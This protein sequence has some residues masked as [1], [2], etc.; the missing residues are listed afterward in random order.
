MLYHLILLFTENFYGSEIWHGNF[1]ELIFVSGMLGGFVR[2]PRDFNGFSF[3]PFNRPVTLTPV[4]CTPMGSLPPQES[5]PSKGTVGK[6]NQQKGRAMNL[7][8]SQGLR[9][10]TSFLIY[11]YQTLRF[12]YKLKLTYI[13]F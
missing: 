13:L 5:H 6:G 11:V 12:I 9:T 8:V 10:E 7:S 4:R 3:G 1:G 2:S